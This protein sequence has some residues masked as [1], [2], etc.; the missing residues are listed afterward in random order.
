MEGIGINLPLLLA[1]VINFV[2]LFTLLGIFLYK[3]VLKMLDERQAKIKDSM[4]QAEQIKEQAAHSE[5]QIKAHL[6]T[7]RK[8]GQAIIAQATQI[9]ERL[10]EEAKEGARQEAESLMAKARTE[11]QRDRDKTIEE[12]RQEFV[13]IAI[14]AAEKVIN[15]TLDREKH[16]KLIGEVLEEN[17]T[18]K[19]S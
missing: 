13:D 15:E 4:E 2:I 12:L 14:L 10:K 19:Q 9:G 3:P 18:F 17:T 11:I 6:E 5:E 8:E 16:R 1:F 7:A